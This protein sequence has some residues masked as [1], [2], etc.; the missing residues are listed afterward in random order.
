M[1]ANDATADIPLES[2]VAHSPAGA[3]R[4]N[5]GSSTAAENEQAAFAK[6]TSMHEGQSSGVFH[7]GMHGRRKL[8]RTTSKD[9]AAGR[10]DGEEDV[11]NRMGM[12]YRK[13]VNFS[14]ITRYFIYILP[15]ASTLR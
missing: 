14:T 9:Q 6:E 3:R 4:T 1:P 7:R 2:V 15:L 11:I 10:S 13:V 12:I 8:V 5:S